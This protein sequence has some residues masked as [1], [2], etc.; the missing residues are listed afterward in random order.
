MILARQW[1]DPHLAYRAT[2][3]AG[4]VDLARLTAVDDALDTAIRQGDLRA[5]LEFNYRFHSD[6]YDLAESPILAD[7]ANGLWLRFGPSLRVVCG[8]VGT[9]N[10]PDRHKEMLS[11]M[12]AGDA[13][14]AARAIRDDVTQGMEQMRRALAA[15]RALR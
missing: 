7:L 1:L 14:A 3:R 5:Y 6:I 15:P 11:A 2:T 10:L 4:A 12:Q 13:G 8:R 9:Q